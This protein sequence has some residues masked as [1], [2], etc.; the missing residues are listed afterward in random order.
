MNGLLKLCALAALAAATWAVWPEQTTTAPVTAGAAIV[1]PA[2][3][4]QSGLPFFA[5]LEPAPAPP[6]GAVSMAATRL[7]G[8]PQA[9]PIAHEPVVRTAPSAQELADPTAYEQY[10]TRETQRTYAAYI[11]AVDEELPRL[12]ADIARG[13]EMGLEASKIAMAE[14]KA[15][16]LGLMREQLVRELQAAHTPPITAKDSR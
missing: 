16:R 10:E 9:P 14:D 15:R 6:T 13:R 5:A 4:A 2:Q 3:K 7:H 8:D 1:A 12:R 11:R